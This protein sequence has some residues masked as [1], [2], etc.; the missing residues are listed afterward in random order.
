MTL[1]K[2]V[3]HNNLVRD[4][5]N[6]AILNTDLSL[7]RKHEKRVVD[8]QKEEAREQ[9]INNLKNDINQIKELLKL[10]LTK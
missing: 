2:I 3:D 10:L 4:L 8:L 6:Q 5:S 1:A 7:V 9:E